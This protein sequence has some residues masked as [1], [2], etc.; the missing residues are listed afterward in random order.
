MTKAPYDPRFEAVFRAAELNK[1]RH[2]V[3]G[4]ELDL[5]DIPFSTVPAYGWEHA[6]HTMLLAAYIAQMVGVTKSYEMDAVKMAGLLHDLG[7]EM[8]W[9]QPDPNHNIRSADKATA[10]LQKKFAPTS[11][12]ERVQVL[13]AQHDLRKEELPR[14]PLAMALW[15]ADA[16]EGWRLAPGTGEGMRVMQQRRFCTAFANDDSIKRHYARSRGWKR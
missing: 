1:Q 2:M 16:L 14:D 7:R 4:K 11:L 12:I 15:D 5:S 3:S 13:I 10:Y 6:Q 8:P 9:Q